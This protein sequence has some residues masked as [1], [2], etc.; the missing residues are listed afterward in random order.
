M[1]GILVGGGAVLLLSPQSDVPTPWTLEE[2]ESH[3]EEG[4]GNAAG[5]S[6]TAGDI[7]V[8]QKREP[9]MHEMIRDGSRNAL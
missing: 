9:I 7:S 3:T 4:L 6:S 1:A 2:V 5:G 8:V